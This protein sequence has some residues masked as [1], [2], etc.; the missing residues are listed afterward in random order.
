M[1]KSVTL[2]HSRVKVLPNRSVVQFSDAP[3][4]EGSESIRP[5]Q[6]FAGSGRSSQ[7]FQLVFPVSISG[8]LAIKQCFY[9][10]AFDADRILV[11]ASASMNFL[12]KG[13][14]ETRGFTS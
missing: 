7:L 1:K 5:L 12:E 3:M 10:T 14:H 4:S 6:R 11:C 13:R 9:Q 8:A 2:C